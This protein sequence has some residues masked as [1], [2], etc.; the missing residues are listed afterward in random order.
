VQHGKVGRFSFA[1][2]YYFLLFNSRRKNCNCRG[3]KYANRFENVTK[4]P[5]KKLA[6][7]LRVQTVLCK[8]CLPEAQ[9]LAR[10]KRT[11][12]GDKCGTRLQKLCTSYDD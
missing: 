9:V 3:S 1:T 12:S 7:S 4:A 10:F 11:D 5:P 2:N 8:H 6:I